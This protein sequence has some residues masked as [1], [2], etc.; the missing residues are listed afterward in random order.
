MIELNASEER[1]AAAIRKAAT[2]GSL[3]VSLEQFSGGAVASGKTLVLLDEV[4][5]LSGGFRK[6]SDHRI[7]GSVEAD[8][9]GILRGDTGGKAELL[10]LLEVT[11]QPVIMTCNDPM[12]LWGRN[13][14]WKRNR[15]RLLR[16]AE[17][18]N[19]SLIHI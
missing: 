18:V 11:Q 17:L 3:H 19:L 5:H 2:Q 1:N 13:R 16:K 14:S 4:D 8:E 6:V 15:D 12:R 10:N 7:E 9:E